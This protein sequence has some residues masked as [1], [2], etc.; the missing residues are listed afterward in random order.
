MLKK[1][2]STALSGGNPNQ[3]LLLFHTQLLLIHKRGLFVNFVMIEKLSCS[4]LVA[5][6]THYHPSRQHM[7]LQENIKER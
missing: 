2:L 4:T 5:T 3:Y 1:G 6:V 7:I